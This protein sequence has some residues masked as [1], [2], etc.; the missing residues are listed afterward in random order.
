MRRMPLLVLLINYKM[1]IPTL[2]GEEW[3]N[4]P[5]EPTAAADVTGT[6]ESQKQQQ[7]NIFQQA[8]DYVAEQLGI[9]DQDDSQALREEGLQ[10]EQDI[11]Q[12]IADDDSVAAEVAKGIFGAPKN[13][14]AKVAGAAEFAGDV[15]GGVAASVGIVDRADEDIPWPTNYEYAQ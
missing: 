10:R 7:L 14:G 8:T 15:I 11:E 1:A 12:Q 5:V 3:M 4:R 6:D 9:R 2:S 13:L